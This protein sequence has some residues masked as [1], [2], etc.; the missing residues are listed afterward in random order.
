M[1]GR[2]ALGWLAGRLSRGDAEALRLWALSRATVFGLSIAAASLFTLDT[3][4]HSPVPFLDTWRQWDVWHFE[5][6][7]TYGYGQGQPTGVPLAAF[8]PGFPLALRALGTLGLDL[9]AAGLLISLVALAVAVVA[10]HRLAL[11]ESPASTGPDTARW[12]VLFLLLAPQAVFLAAPYSE[13]LF[14]A[15]AVPAWLAARRGRWPLAGILA[16]GAVATRITGVFLVAGLLVMFLTAPETRGRRRVWGWAWLALSAV[17]LLAF[18]WQLHRDTGD[19]LAWFHAQAQGWGRHFSD[20]AT[21]LW[22]TLQMA[23]GGKLLERDMMVVRLEI[24]AVLLGIA[25]SAWL[26]RRHRWPELTYVGLQVLALATSSYY[27]S[28]ARA[29]L[30]WFPLFIALGQ[31]SLRRRWIRPAYL[32]FVAPAMAVFTLLFTTGRWAG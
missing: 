16:A 20:P 12:S 1:T 18:M 11:V 5:A 29:T 22:R 15:F 14:L 21:A 7:A 23:F 30:L 19:W 13:S 31:A 25:A 10:L 27:M 32:W 17:P 4:R 6:V 28:V 2:R 3:Q 9:T 26:W 8:F 24:V